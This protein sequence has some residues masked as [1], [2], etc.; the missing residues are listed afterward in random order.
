MNGLNTEYYVQRTE[1]QQVQ[2]QHLNVHE[3]S[4]AYA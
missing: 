3:S 2:E 1:E 4:L